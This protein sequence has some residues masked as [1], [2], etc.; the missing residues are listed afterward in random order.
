MPPEISAPSVQW[1]ARHGFL[2]LYWHRFI[3]RSLNLPRPLDPTHDHIQ[4]SNVFPDL[5]RRHFMNANALACSLNEVLT[6][7]E[8]GNNGYAQAAQKAHKLPERSS[9][10][11]RTTGNNCQPPVVPLD[12]GQQQ[13][14]CDEFGCIT[15]ID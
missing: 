3:Y 13:Q 12:L 1:L 9:V 11:A 5:I 14:L 6:V 15:N 10:V 8:N 7:A 4:L 2:S